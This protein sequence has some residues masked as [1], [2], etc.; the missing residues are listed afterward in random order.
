[1]SVFC[2]NSAWN[3]EVS[4]LACFSDFTP[5]SLA[6]GK[7]LVF[8]DRRLGIYG[9]SA[10]MK[11]LLATVN[12]PPSLLGRSSKPEEPGTNPLLTE[13][14]RTNRGSTGAPASQSRTSFTLALPQPVVFWHC[15]SGCAPVRSLAR[16]MTC[17]SWRACQTRDLGSVWIQH[18]DE[19][20]D[21]SLSLSLSLS[22]FLFLFLFL[23]PWRGMQAPILPQIRPALALP[24]RP[25]LTQLRRLPG[26][27]PLPQPC[28]PT[29]LLIRPLPSRRRQRPGEPASHPEPASRLPLLHQRYW[30]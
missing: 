28:D 17:P 5:C 2:C 23:P 13:S 9:V 3:R 16:T 10:P 19:D 20:E 4:F 29:H 7:G 15:L 26:L 12:C 27:Q 11:R 22:L 1:M 8:K 25:I 14:D 21:W 6:A 30:Q 18:R 24:Q